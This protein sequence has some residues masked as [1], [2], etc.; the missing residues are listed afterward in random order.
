M[1][2]WHFIHYLVSL[3]LVVIA[4]ALNIKWLAMIASWSLVTW[5]WL[6]RF[7]NRKEL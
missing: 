5:V 3:Q 7:N 4:C 6:V 1:R 2:P